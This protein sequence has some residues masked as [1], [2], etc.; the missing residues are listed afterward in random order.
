MT[1]SSILQACTNPSLELMRWQG[2]DIGSHLRRLDKN[3]AHLDS[4]NQPSMGWG[5][6]QPEGTRIQVGNF[7]RTPFQ[8]RCNPHLGTPLVVL[9]RSDN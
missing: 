6:G 4:S 5:P 8:P 3:A 7:R 1:E 9:K 2:I